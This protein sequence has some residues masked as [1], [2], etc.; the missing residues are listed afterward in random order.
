[1]RM[2]ILV[3]ILF[4]FNVDN[5]L[6]FTHPCDSSKGHNSTLCQELRKMCLTDNTLSVCEKLEERTNIGIALLNPSVDVNYA[7]PDNFLTYLTNIP[8]DLI[9]FYSSFGFHVRRGFQTLQ[10]NLQSNPLVR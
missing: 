8:G 6:S 9:D 7:A 10:R 4:I 5:C 1:M 3:I 2:D